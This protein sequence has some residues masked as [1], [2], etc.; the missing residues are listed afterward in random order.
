M[1]GNFSV[2][3]RALILVL[4]VAVAFILIT[5]TL[6]LYVSQREAERALNEQVA[7]VQAQNE[8]LAR[9]IERWQDPAYI[10][11][12][13]RERL[14]YVLPGQQPYVVIDPEVVV[15]EEEQQ[16]YEDAQATYVAPRGP[17]YSQMMDSIEIAGNAEAAGESAEEP[18]DE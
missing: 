17:W 9:L 8:E 15:G 2:S 3:W 16:A 12:Q 5:P 18:A 14:G 11:A 7:A 4:V 6:R 1:G 10:E 13:A